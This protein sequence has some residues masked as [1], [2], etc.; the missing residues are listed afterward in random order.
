MAS[1]V[2]VATASRNTMVDALAALLNSGTINYYSGTQPATA[3]TAHSG[4]T[5]LCTQTF[6]ATAFGASSSGTATANAVTSGVIG[7]SGTVAWAEILTSGAAISFHCSVGT[8]ASDIT[9]PTV[10]FTASVTL[11]MSSATLSIAA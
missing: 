5:L 1:N 4:N 10:T 11:T 8:S 2:H 3:N 7:T 6:G 9:V